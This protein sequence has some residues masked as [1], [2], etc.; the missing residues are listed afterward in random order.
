M[1]HAPVPRPV[2]GSPLHLVVLR[3]QNVE[4][5]PSVL[6]F[7]RGRGLIVEADAVPPVP[8]HKGDRVLLA[9][10]VEDG[11]YALRGV[12]SEVLAPTRI[13]VI[14][15]AAP[16]MME[17]R[18]YI[19]AIV[20]VESA[21]VVGQRAPQ[22]GRA[23]TE[24]SVELSA[25]GFR[26][27]GHVAAVAGDRAWLCLRL[28]GGTGARMD[29]RSTVVR[30]EPCGDSFEVAGHFDDLQPEVR[31]AILDLVFRRRLSDLGIQ[32]GRSWNDDA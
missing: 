7:D 11:L 27:F 5:L 26:W 31:E 15:G 32:A 20:P 28:P 29:V 4:V 1:E 21:L 22:A 30:A 3:D 16:V 10:Q 14:P 25:S 8:F 24:T 13:Y 23:L 12:L 19:R 6:R 2:V 17:K 9:Y 18:E